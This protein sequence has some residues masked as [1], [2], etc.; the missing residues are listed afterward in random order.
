MP[1]HEREAYAFG[2]FELDLTARSLT[3]SGSPISLAPKTFDLLAMLVRRPGILFS[4]REIIEEL[5]PDTFVEEANLSFQ[6]A[7]LRKALGESANRWIETVPKHGYRFKA[8]TR[9]LTTDL[10]SESSSA[11]AVGA[12]GLQRRDPTAPGSGTKRTRWR[13]ILGL[14]VMAMA[15]LPAGWQIARRYRHSSPALLVALPLTTYRGLDVDP[16]IS[17]DGN[18]VAFAWDGPKQNNLDI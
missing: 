6:V 4:K 5:W 2:D 12:L 13:R 15:L 18:Q 17:P 1:S 16:S 10:P 3:K 7:A 14:A 9:R 11:I 8:P